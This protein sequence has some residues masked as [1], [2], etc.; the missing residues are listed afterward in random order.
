MA[1]PGSA[2]GT[3]EK[4]VFDACRLFGNWGRLLIE[5]GSTAIDLVGTPRNGAVGLVWW[6]KGRH[7]RSLGHD[8]AFASDGSDW[9]KDAQ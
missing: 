8:C 3:W 1:R 2:P 5:F 4:A 6:L 7:V 9:W